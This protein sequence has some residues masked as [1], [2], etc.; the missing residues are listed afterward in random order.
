M[1]QVESEKPRVLEYTRSMTVCPRCGYVYPASLSECPKC[2][3]I[4]EIIR[5]IYKG[6]PGDCREY[7]ERIRRKLRSQG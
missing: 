5:D 2:S 3:V 6:N 7:G 4:L 1:T